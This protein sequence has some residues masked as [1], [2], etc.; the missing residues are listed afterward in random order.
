LL[1]C[2]KPESLFLTEHSSQR[3]DESIAVHIPDAAPHRD[4]LV[5]RN[6]ESRSLAYPGCV[7]I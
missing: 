5:L 2:G 6:S 1:G 4:A 3:D 7:R